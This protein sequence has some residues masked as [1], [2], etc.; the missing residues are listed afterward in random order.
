MPPLVREDWSYLYLLSGEVLTEIEGH[1]YL[2][3]AG[4][5]LLIPPGLRYCVKYFRD[6]VGYMGAFS[7]ELLRNSGHRVLRLTAPSV[8]SVPVLDKVFFDELMIRLM[9]F[10]SSLSMVQ[11]LL[12]VLLC[13]FDLI[14]PESGGSASSKLCTSYL[15]RVFDRSVPFTGVAGYASALEASEKPRRSALGVSP[16]HLNRA[17][18]AETGRNASVWID[19]ARI[20]LARELLLDR[21]MSMSEIAERLGFS[22]ASYFSRFF[23]KV[24]GVSPSEFRG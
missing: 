8:L 16:N 22:E 2:L 15:E 18:K 9:R 24:T 5:C 17:V 3:A 14:V 7:A 13:Q 11:S 21:S 23:R 6:T 20:S 10:S 12:D 1:P 4:D 19:N